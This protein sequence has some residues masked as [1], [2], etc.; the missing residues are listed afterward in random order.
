M[1]IPPFFVVATP[2]RSVCDDNARAL[3][4]AG[5]L[6][7]YMIGQRRGTA[8]IPEELTGKLQLLGAMRRV[9]ELALPVFRAESFRFRLHPWFD[10]WVCQQLQPGDHLISSYG[11]ANSSFDWIR[12][13]GGKTYLDGGNSHPEN[14]WQIISEEHRRWNCPY[15]P[16]APH[17]YRRSMAMMEKVDFVLSPSRFV[18]KSFLDRG[19]S[20]DQILPSTYPVSFSPE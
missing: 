5:Y 14:F 10:R 1:N 18:T 6:R 12:R 19:F 7:R 20:P 4:Q 16:V 3:V 2:N 17:H 9:T 8:G 15:P 13:H 11:Y